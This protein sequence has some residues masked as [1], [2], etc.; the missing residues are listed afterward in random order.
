MIIFGTKAGAVR[1]PD[2]FHNILEHP[3]VQVEVAGATLN[4]KATVLEGPDRDA[5]WAQQCL[6]RPEFAI[7]QARSVR[8]IPVIA[9]DRE[10]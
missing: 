1:H 9:L 3:Q 2:W 8:K 4:A 6:E 10:I 5:L 7:Y